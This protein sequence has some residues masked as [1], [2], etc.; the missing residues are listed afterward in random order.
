M[1]NV[2]G[3]QNDETRNSAKE[4]KIVRH[5]SFVIPSSFVLRHSA[6]AS[7]ELRSNSYTFF[8]PYDK[9]LDIGKPI[10]QGSP[11]IRRRRA[12]PA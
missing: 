1:T 8:R 2:E 10:S 3:S 5:L 9:I 11:L 4:R 6:G 12:V 7:E